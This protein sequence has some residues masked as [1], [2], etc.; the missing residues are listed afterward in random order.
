MEQ[1]RHVFL[2]R[3]EELHVVFSRHVHS[4]V[5]T[6]T[7]ETLRYSGNV[8]IASVSIQSNQVDVLP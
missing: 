2:D 8:F 3:C 4:D 7:K 6:V 1:A 5:H